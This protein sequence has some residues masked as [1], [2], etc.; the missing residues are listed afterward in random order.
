MVVGVGGS[1]AFSKRIGAVVNC[2]DLV[3][4]GA[5]SGGLRIAGLGRCRDTVQV[6]FH[7]L[8]RTMDKMGRRRDILAL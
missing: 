7:S 6:K 2:R 5:W 8:F 4:S 3:A 1:C